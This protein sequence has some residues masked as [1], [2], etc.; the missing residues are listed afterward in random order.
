MGRYSYLA[1]SNAITPTYHVCL[2]FFFTSWAKLVKLKLAKT[3][4]TSFYLLNVDRTF[5]NYFEFDGK[6]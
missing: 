1:L 6:F 4:E 3:S 5:E 2:I